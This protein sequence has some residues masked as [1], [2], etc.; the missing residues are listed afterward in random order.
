MFNRESGEME[1]SRRFKA[2]SGKLKRYGTQ[3]IGSSYIYKGFE[4]SS[5]RWDEVQ[6]SWHWETLLL[7]VGMEMLRN[8]TGRISRENP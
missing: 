5:C 8:G 6:W 4:R 3:M 1:L 7:R 2:D